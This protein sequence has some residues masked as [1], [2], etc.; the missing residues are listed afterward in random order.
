MGLFNTGIFVGEFR[1]SLDDKGRLTI[2]S[3]WRLK[4]DS[5]ENQFLALQSVEDGASAYVVVYP[6]KMIAQLEERI[7][8][9]S[10]GDVE[11]QRMLGELMSMAHSFNCD[12]QGR[13]SLNG[14]LIQH[15]QIGKNAVL[16][17]RM[18]TFS[19]HSEALYDACQAEGPSDPAARAEVF[20]RFGL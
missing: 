4:G 15:S 8:Q 2:P 10:M 1:H 20:K 5:E 11:G 9:I 13:M 17:G 19:I 3:A 7:S 16:L 18:S 12:K 6:T 14:K